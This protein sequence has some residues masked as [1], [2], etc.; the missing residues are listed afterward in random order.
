MFEYYQKIFI[1]NYI[2]ASDC[3]KAPNIVT[4]EDWKAQ[5]NLKAIQFQRA[6]FEL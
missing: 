4:S 6:L 5:N 3:K 2:V 1:I